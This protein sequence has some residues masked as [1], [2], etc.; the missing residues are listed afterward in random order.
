[1][2]GGESKVIYCIDTDAYESNYEQKKELD[3]IKRFCEKNGY[4]LVW[5][6][7]DVEEVFLGK[8]VE[9]SQKV[10]EAGAFRSSRGIERVRED[11][12]SVAGIRNKCSNLLRV[13]GQYLERK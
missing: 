13:L 4:D 2:G 10:K 11:K 5:F 8:Q 7:H 3:D 6:C 1:M 9:N 12:L